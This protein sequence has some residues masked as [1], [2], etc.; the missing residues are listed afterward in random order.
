MLGYRGGERVKAGP[1]WNLTKG[2]LVSLSGQD[3]V[4]PGGSDERYMKA[5]LPLLMVFGPL[6]GLAYVIFLPFIGFATVA[7]L[8]GQRARWAIEA[9][10]HAI[11]QTAAV[12]GW[13]PGMAQ[14]T[15]RGRHPQQALTREKTEAADRKDELA[16]LEEE[17]RAQRREREKGDD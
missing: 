4:L 5:P 17:V 7:M 11:I 3:G 13:V 10:G 8:L 16:A 6:A 2:E 15:R 12:P 14:L 9:G 1:Y